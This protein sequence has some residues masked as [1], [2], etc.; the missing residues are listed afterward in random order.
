M[1]KKK[2]I[3]GFFVIVFIAGSSCSYYSKFCF[4]RAVQD[5]KESGKSYQWYTRVDETSNIRETFTVVED[6]QVSFEVLI[7]S[8]RGEVDVVIMDENEVEIYVNQDIRKAEN[9]L[10]NLSRGTY[11][12]DI[13]FKY[14][15][16]SF[17]YTYDDVYI[18]FEGSK[19]KYTEIEEIELDEDY[20]TV[21]GKDIEKGFFW[22]YIL[23]IPDIISCDYILVTPNNTGFCS[24]DINTH[25]NS[26][27]I[28]MTNYSDLANILGSVLLMP[29]F[30]RPVSD[31]VYYS[32]SF[33]RNTIL[34]EQEDMERLDL[35]LLAMIDDARERVQSDGFQ[36]DKKIALLGFSASGDF[37]DRFTFLH[38]E[39]V[40][41][42]VF[43]GCSLMVPLSEYNGENLPYPIGIFDYRELTGKEFPAEEFFLVP[44]F[45]FTGDKDEGGNMGDL[46]GEE[47]FNKF[48][49]ESLV[50]SIDSQK[51]PLYSIS[52]EYKFNENEIRYSAFEGAM[53][54]NQFK[55]IKN[56]NNELGL[57]NTTSNIYE[58]RDHGV[59]EEMQHDILE[60]FSDNLL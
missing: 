27:K 3:I 60:F 14:Y 36:L 8:T 2:L 39:R 31:N 13:R 52:N 16:G 10:L 4:E 20:Y 58:N 11:I 7:S 49:L 45:V 22:D 19:S 50:K 44:R 51:K 6:H 33:D 26:A 21:V 37:V 53:F 40:K 47:H 5:I 12:F 59:Y 29:V 56:I 38:P 25:F 1:K 32:H 30:P 42:A 46:T 48:E 28:G 15:S 34:L 43:G 9:I 24:P 17:L 57:T 23:Y 55:F 18:Q 41:A 54:F 35:Q